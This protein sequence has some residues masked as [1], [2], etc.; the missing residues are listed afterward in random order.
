MGL[1]NMALRNIMRKSTRTLLVSLALCF[2]IASIISVYSGTEASNADTKQMIAEYQ[3][4]LMEVG[5]L[6]NTQ[7][8]MI[9]VSIGRGGFGGGG[10]FWGGGGTAGGE[11]VLTE[12]ELAGISGVENVETVIPKISKNVGEVDWEQ[13]RTM[14]E[15]MRES[16]QGMGQGRE[17]MRTFMDSLFDYTIQGIPLD[18]EFVSKYSLLPEKIVKGSTLTATDTGSVLIRDS[19]TS[20]FSG[21]VGDNI[22]IE[23]QQFTVKGLYESD[24]TRKNV[25]MNVADAQA[26]TDMVGQYSTFDVYVTDKSYVD[27]AVYDIS[28][29]YPD[30][31]VQSY[32]E[33]S[34]RINERIN[35]VQE[36]QIKSLKDDNDKV[37]NTGLQIIA[38]STATAGL[39]VLFMMFYTVKER[40]KEIGIFKAL[41]FQENSIMFQFIAEGA[42]IGF[43]GGTFGVAI[44]WAGAPILADFLLPSS[45]S[46]ATITPSFNLILLGLGLAAG[47]G[48]LGSIYPAW[49][50]SR[51]SPAEAIRGG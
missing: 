2:A 28:E 1:L 18:D 8:S 42:I 17:D 7:E 44:G 10:G 29:L 51:K 23:G 31:R 38:V 35:T 21:G 37:E 39:I 14:R 30:I 50:A 45:D 25:Y 27:L 46:Y 36:D 16:G 22:T 47:L 15:E 33:L 5:E 24:D 41:G 11:A 3:D 48:I 9:Q 34:E 12:T 40:T 32:A 13:M 19:L 26:A 4:T 43:I 49:K 6:T 20:F